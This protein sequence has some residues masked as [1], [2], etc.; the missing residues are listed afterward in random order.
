LTIVY[1][2]IAIL[3][4]M[5]LI[6]VHEFGHYIT[7]KLLKFQINEFSIGFGKAIYKKTKKNGEVFSIRMV[8]LGGFCAFEGEDEDNPN[9]R[10]FNNQKPWKRMVVLAGGVVFNFV[11]GV[12]TAAIYLMVAGYSVP[13][14]SFLTPGNQNTSFLVGD[15]IV[16]VDGVSI[17]S[18]RN[19][20]SLV[21]KYGKNETFSVTVERKVGDT[22]ELVILDDVKKFESQAFYFASA[23]ST[24]KKIF[25]DVGGVATEI[26]LSEFN[27]YLLIIVPEKNQDG[28]IKDL[29]L[30]NETT[31]FYK[32]ENLSS[33]NAYTTQE[34]KELAGIVLSQGGTSLGFVYLG[35]QEH[36]GFFESLLKAW[37]FSFYLCSVILSALGGLFTGATK[38]SDMG[39]TFTAIAQMAEV[40][41]LGFS[42]FLLLLPLLS[43]NLA[44]FNFLP[45]PSL[46][47]ART[48]FVGIEAIRG[49]PINPKVEGWIHTI[50]LMLL[51]ALVLFLDG[52]QLITRLF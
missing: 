25:K 51:L 21:A 10:A 46:D 39:G 15:K 41:S 13:Q 5:L 17:E 43:M 49:K 38:L 29:S 32:S 14:I 36:Y 20:S 33:E 16:A 22:Y 11:F 2:L 47:G 40:T 48:V 30:N 28:S 44:L 4:L 8:P 26:S 19:M 35:V 45:I 23:I 6:T 50:G 27:D 12:I 1:I 42:Q 3:V 9:P 34:L 18:Y 7:G 24:N 37:P 52:Y 31:K